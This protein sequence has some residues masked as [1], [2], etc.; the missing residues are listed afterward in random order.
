MKEEATRMAAKKPSK[1]LKLDAGEDE[2]IPEGITE[3]QQQILEKVVSVQREIDQL[4]ERASEEILH[5]EQKYNKLRTPF[6]KKRSDLIRELPDFWP[7]TVSYA[8]SYQVKTHFSAGLYLCHTL[9]VH[10]GSSVCAGCISA[11]QTVVISSINQI[12]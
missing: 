5:V 11:A 9:S 4:N 7:T 12:N 3:E 1:V 8:S 2:G 10:A 6:F